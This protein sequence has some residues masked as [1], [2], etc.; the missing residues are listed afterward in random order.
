MRRQPYD[1]S[2]EP[3]SRLFVPLQFWFCRNPGSYLPLLALQYHQ[4]RINLTLRPLS[5]LVIPDPASITNPSVPC[6]P[7]YNT[8]NNTID[9]MLYGDYVFLDVDE[10]RRF[11]STAHEYLIEQVQC[12]RYAIPSIA[13]SVTVPVVFNHPI[14][15]FFWFIQRDDLI[16]NNFTN[17]N[18]TIEWFNYS[19]LG[20][21]EYGIRTD[22]M[23]EAVIQFDGFD[24][25]YAR[26]PGY[27]RLVQPY[28][29]HTAIP[30][31]S[32]IYAYAFALRPEEVQP[33]GSANA[34]R[35]DNIVFQV[36]LTTTTMPPRGNSSFVV[37]AINNNVF[38]V[39]DGFGGLL[40]TV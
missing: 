8:A 12:S 31:D 13:A 28:L 22:I 32:F 3:G 37:Y 1:A 30:A 39:I 34:S 10:R 29:H 33:S 38:R 18:N 5:D 7:V 14:K 36:D 15:E 6:I 19:S 24:R 40:F 17:N 25:F 27:F 9:V 2:V 23:T 16:R 11:V 26:D 35:I 21:Y 20:M 4:V